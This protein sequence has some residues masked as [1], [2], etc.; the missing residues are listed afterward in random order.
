MFQA[1]LIINEKLECYCNII[2]SELSQVK[3]LTNT[4]INAQTHKKA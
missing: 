4:C 1:V 3:N 2:A